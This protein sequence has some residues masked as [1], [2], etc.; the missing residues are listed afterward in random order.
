MPQFPQPP[1]NKRLGLHYFPDTYHYRED[2]LRAWSPL[3][4]STG[5]TWL[6]LISPLHRAIPESFLRGLIDIGIEPVLHFYPPLVNSHINTNLELLFQ[7]YK[8]WG[9]QYTI[10]FDRPNIRKTWSKSEW[11]QMDLVE[12]FLDRFT[13]I[14]ETAMHTGLIPVFP[15]LEPG[16]DF[17][18]IAFLKAALVSLV[19]R[20]KNE[21]LNQLVL[22]AYARAG[23]RPLDWGAGGPERWPVA[24]PYF[25]PPGVQD[26][27]GFRIFDWYLATARASTGRSL[28]IILLGVGSQPSLNNWQSEETI[29]ETAQSLRTLTIA[30]R[31]NG[32]IPEPHLADPLSSIQDEVL[33]C[34]F[35]LMSAS[36]ADEAA[37]F[38]WFDH[39][40]CP[41]QIAVML[42]QFNEA[43]RDRGKSHKKVVRQLTHPQNSVRATSIAHPIAHY[44]LLP[45]FDWGVADWHLE[46][47]QPFVKKY[48]PTIGFS[49]LEASHAARVTV[50]DEYNAYQEDAL[51]MLCEAGCIVE[52]MD[53]DG[54]K[55]AR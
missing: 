14:A 37:K 21:L 32:E 36:P 38:A 2:D 16:G 39:A 10:L 52:I 8:R 33:A 3:I 30:K 40:G 29:D 35:W 47:I 12:R 25:T 22:S 1:N 55:I 49:L 17:W 27:L 43:Q 45:S 5:I 34:N 48:K 4:R 11:S 31:L 18:D 53:S 54:M 44:L 15:P 41:T 24:R 23:D 9:V 51:E 28:P 7:T 46:A 50:F 6:V 13:P 42:Q 26:H 19:R 20:G